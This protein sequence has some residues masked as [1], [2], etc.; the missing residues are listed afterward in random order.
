MVRRWTLSLLAIDNQNEEHVQCC[1]ILLLN[2][3]PSTKLRLP[4]CC[5]S[6]ACYEPIILASKCC[7]FNWFPMVVLTTATV[8]LPASPSSLCLVASC[9]T[10]KVGVSKTSCDAAKNSPPTSEGKVIQR[11][12]SNWSNSMILCSYCIYMYVY[13]IHVFSCIGNIMQHTSVTSL[14]STSFF[15]QKIQHVQSPTHHFCFKRNP[16]DCCG[17]IP[18]EALSSSGPTLW[19]P[20]LRSRQQSFASAKDGG[21]P[22]NQAG[23][24]QIFVVPCCSYKVLMGALFGFIFFWLWA[25]R[26]HSMVWINMVVTDSSGVYIST[27]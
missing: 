20:P 18:W 4:E 16:K 1:R 27:V 13:H 24:R 26:D 2:M 19:V 9:P 10:Y 5:C 11:R 6:F 15:S 8:Q 14:F 25:C 23:E 12:G 17:R 22:N 21:K 3:L 7:R